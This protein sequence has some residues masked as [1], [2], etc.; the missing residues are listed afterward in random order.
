MFSGSYVFVLILILSS[1][2]IT[3]LFAGVQAQQNGGQAD[4]PALVHT[5]YFWF[6]EDVSEEESRDFYQELLKLQEIP[7]IIHGWIGVPASTEQRGVI[8][9]SYDYSITFVFNSVE[10]EAEYQVHPVHTEF[11]EKN[12]RLW[13]RVVVYDAIT[14]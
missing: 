14:P 2:M 13:E 7:Q 9:S 8:D 11:V 5:V 10:A 4:D 3:P 6:N 1:F 12:S